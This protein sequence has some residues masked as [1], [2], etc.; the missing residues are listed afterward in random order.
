[1]CTDDEHDDKKNPWRFRVPDER[2]TEDTRRLS[3]LNVAYPLAPVGSDA[4]GGAE[5]VLAMLDAHLALCGHRSL[6]VACEGS[7]TAGVLLAT[8]RPRAPFD[9]DVRRAAHEAHRRTIDEALRSGEVDLVHLHGIDFHEYLP[10]T[11]LPVLVTL[12]LP[13]AWYPE[14]VLRDVP[15]NVHLLCVSRS[16]AATAPPGIGPLPVIENGVAI[17]AY[18]RVRHVKRD[19][20]LCL[21]RI[22]PEK[23]YDI[24]LRAARAADVALLLAGH[25][26]PY[27]AHERHFRDCIEPLLD[28]QRR[29]IGTVGFK[30]KRRL[31]AAARCLVVPSLAPETSSLVAMEALACG[32]PVVAF[33]SGALAEIVEEGRTGFLVH[34]EGEMAQAIR[35][36]SRLGAD[37]CRRAARERFDLAHTARRY[38]ELYQSLAAA[39]TTND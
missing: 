3:V 7:R 19:F 18:G 5:Q 21:G 38:L 20:A 10:Q 8:S 12:H 23:G 13:L 17:E 32:T 2:K 11:R 6:V 28:G 37:A 35:A 30:R 4:V 22:C 24:A 36:A 16:Q 1:M 33:P 9:D 27:E 39:G 34:S 14:R 25:V 31:L 15:P 29:F 26:F